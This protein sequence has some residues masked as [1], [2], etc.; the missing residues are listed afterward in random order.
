MVATIETNAYASE[1]N[2]YA[3]LPPMLPSS[4]YYGSFSHVHK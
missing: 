3:L 2:G 1:F 4:T